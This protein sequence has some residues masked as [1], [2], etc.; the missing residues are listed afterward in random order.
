MLTAR[1][2]LDQPAELSMLPMHGLQCKHLQKNWRVN[3][4]LQRS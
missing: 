4:V 3:A 1:V 2:V